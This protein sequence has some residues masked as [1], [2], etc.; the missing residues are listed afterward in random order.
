MLSDVHNRVAREFGLVFS[1]PETMRP[2]YADFGIDLP[3]AN[4]DETF[5]LP[6]PA[7]YVI[8]PDATILHAFVDADYTNRLEPTVI[9]EV[10]QKLTAEKQ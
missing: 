10:L 1:L 7:T 5:E 4:G 8:G 3:A 2:I 6:M 9:L